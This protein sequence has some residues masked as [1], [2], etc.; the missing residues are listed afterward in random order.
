MGEYSE[1]GGPAS[2]FD[3]CIYGNGPGNLPGGL[4]AS[5]FN[6]SYTRTPSNFTL[7]LLRLVTLA[8]AP[9]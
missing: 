3:V 7:N 8:P 4:L 2:S 9:Y 1:G 5:R 6:M